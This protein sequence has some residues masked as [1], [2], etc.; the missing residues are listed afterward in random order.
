M[1]RS[2]G[3]G[4]VGAFRARSHHGVALL[5]LVAAIVLAGLIRPVAPSTDA[6]A[7]H[8]CDSSDPLF[9]PLS[10]S[11]GDHAHRYQRPAHQCWSK[12]EMPCYAG[13]RG[14][15]ARS[16]TLK[17]KLRAYHEY[18]RECDAKEDITSLKTKLRAGNATECRYLLWHFKPGDG[19]GNQ[20][21]SLVSAFVYALLTNRVFLLLT[22]MGPAKLMCQPFEG[23]PWFV[24]SDVPNERWDATLVGMRIAYQYFPDRVAAVQN[25][26][27][28]TM[29]VPNIANLARLRALNPTPRP[30]NTSHPPSSTTPPFPLSAQV[31]LHHTEQNTS[32]FFCPSEQQWLARVPS[33]LLLAN[34]F[35]LPS[36]FH[37]PSFHR[38]I[39]DLFPSGHIFQTVSQLVM[40][41]NNRLWAAIT[42]NIHRRAA[43]A[44]AR[45]GLQLRHCS[46]D[47]I[48]QAAECVVQV[49]QGDA[50]AEARREREKR[51]GEREPGGEPGGVGA[52]GGVGGAGEGG[53]AG[54]S[55]EAVAAAAAVAAGTGEATSAY[56]MGVASEEGTSAAVAVALALQEGGAPAAAAAAAAAAAGA[57]AAPEGSGSMGESGGGVRGSSSSTVVLIAALYEYAPYN[58][59][60]LLFPNA[61]SSPLTYTKTAQTGLDTEVQH[62]IIDIY[63]LAL[64]S[65]AILI[66]PTSTFG[67]LLSSLF[68]RPAFFVS[69]GCQPAPL[70]PCYQHPPQPHQCSDG[71]QVGV[72]PFSDLFARGGGGGGEQL[73]GDESLVFETSKGVQVLSS[74]EQ[75]GI[76]EDLLRGIYA[77]GFEKPS[78]IQQR[79]IKPIIAGRDVIAQAQSGTGKTSMIGLAVCQVVDTSS[80]ETQALILSP[81]R[82]LAVQT[83]KTVLAVGDFMNV[84]AY[85]CIGGRSIGEDIRKLEFG[86]QVVSGTPGRVYDMIKRR[87]LRTRAIKLLILDESD[88][89]LNMGFKD[90]IYDIYRYLPPEL[91]VVLVSAT[92]PHE[93]LEMTNKF[94]TDPVRILV[95]RDELTLEGIK[96]FFVAVEREEWKFD[97][98]CDLYDTLTI[99]Q[100][101]AGFTA[102]A[103]HATLTITQA[104][105]CHATLTI[106]QARACHATLTI[107]QARA[108][109]ATLSITQACACHATLTITQARACHATLSITQACACHAT[110]TITQARAC[111]ATL[112]ITQAHACHATLTITQARACHA[113]LSITQA[114]ACHTLHHP[115]HM[116]HSPSSIVFCHL[117]L[118]L[119]HS[120]VTLF[121]LA[122]PSL[123]RSPAHAKTFLHSKNI[124]TPLTPSALRHPPLPHLPTPLTPSLP[125]PLGRKVD[126]LTEKM[127]ANNFTVSAMHGDMPQKERDAIMTEFRAG[128]TRVLITTD[129]WARGIDVQQVSLVINYDL[130]NSRELYIHRI[131][132]SGRFGRKGVAINFVRSDDIRILRDIEQYYS[133]QIDEMPMNRKP[134]RERRR[135]VFVAFAGVAMAG[136]AVAVGGGKSEEELRR[137]I[138]EIERQQAQVEDSLRTI[139]SRLP[140]SIRRSLPPAPPAI[141]GQPL[142]APRRFPHPGGASDPAGGAGGRAGGL[143]VR[144]AHT[145]G[146]GWGGIIVPVGQPPP[147]W[148]SVCGAAL[149]PCA[150]PCVLLFLSTHARI[151]SFHRPCCSHTL[152]PPLSPFPASTPFP[153]SSPVPASPRLHRLSPPV[154]APSRLHRLSPPSPPLPPSPF[155]SPLLQSNAALPDGDMAGGTKRR[156]LMSAVTRVREWGLGDMGEKGIEGGG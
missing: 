63:T 20:F 154:P 5:S 115:G 99:T 95:K 39:Q 58:L 60:L 34:Q 1:T 105:A 16:E 18:R 110:L 129:V 101:R 107:T 19:Q 150:P 43:P 27:S 135:V 96:Q 14:M 86:V 73:A 15:A 118:P 78:A 44:A 24:Y 104:R 38:H 92:L 80:R 121:L 22:G 94:M 131:G 65:D 93:I 120:H 4:R 71:Q 59:S 69:Q 156:R 114:R 128:T 84:Q 40:F 123:P 76:R 143:S 47:I 6:P 77:F 45:V 55:G 74:F 122:S 36:L 108:C 31:S 109:H 52:V 46:A 50:V 37:H 89:M 82:E 12:A 147:C 48:S 54:G 11:A 67:Y 70:E 85:A 106:T 51:E 7:L 111:H 42:D 53:A 66:F 17:R 138:E 10:R 3:H 87:S 56:G 137:E 26:T 72:P 57:A 151:I 125:H 97:T 113:T 148:P 116:P 117:A 141:R 126:W 112:T 140:P 8:E 103:C 49:A 29:D 130:P 149:P 90:Q 28:D 139:T 142:R 102:R 75:M 144:A 124:I 30:I 25:G 35:F 98:L 61:P 153:A 134:R 13:S 133:T 32:L 68:G 88:E 155:P 136:S 81:T 146:M 119:C 23:A 127:R 64:A 21:I 79:A 152:I 9:S 2:Q 145:G 41:P 62:A 33:I 83:E 100:A 91:Q 132:R